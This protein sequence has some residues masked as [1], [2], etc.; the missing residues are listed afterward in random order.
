MTSNR[1]F[2]VIVHFYELVDP[3][4]VFVNLVTLDNLVHGILNLFK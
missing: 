3:E 4:I 2:E 1:L